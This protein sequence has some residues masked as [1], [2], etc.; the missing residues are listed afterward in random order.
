MHRGGR[1]GEMAGT[2]LAT[3]VP[4]LWQLSLQLWPLTT[5]Q[6]EKRAAVHWHCGF[7]PLPPVYSSTGAT[8]EL[9]CNSCRSSKRDLSLLDAVVPAASRSWAVVVMGL[10]TPASPLHLT[11]SP[12]WQCLRP[13]RLWMQWRH[14]P[15]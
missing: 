15:S 11:P 5:A 8:R 13:I 9:R 7:G 3:L 14:S 12:R 2:M 1:T 4:L 6:Q 10:A